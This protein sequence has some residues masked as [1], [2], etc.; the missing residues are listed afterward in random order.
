MTCKILSTETILSA[1][2][3]TQTQAPA[4]T[5]IL[6]VQSLSYTQLKNAAAHTSILT[7]QS[8]SLHTTYKQKLETDEDSGTEWK[9]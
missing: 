6:T 7:I 2:M 4:H 8:L 3:H 9:T 5:S 1:Y